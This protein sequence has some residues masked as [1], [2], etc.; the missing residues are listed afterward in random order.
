MAH[1]QPQQVV[2]GLTCRRCDLCDRWLR[3]TDG[4]IDEVGQII[5]QSSRDDDISGKKAKCRQIRG[6]QSH[7]HNIRSEIFLNAQGG[8]HILI[9]SRE[10]EHYRR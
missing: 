3:I 5:S 6:A 2:S 4:V 8:H 7:G 9:I 10:G 1:W